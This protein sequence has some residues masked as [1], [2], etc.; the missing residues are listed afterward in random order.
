MIGRF[1]RNP[2]SSAYEATDPPEGGPIEWL[3]LTSFRI[4][5]LLEAT[6]I[7]RFYTYR[8]RIERFHHVPEKLQLDT[9]QRLENALATYTIVA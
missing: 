5:D 7:L 2:H 1:H 3:L 4:Q 6:Q 8:W 9:R